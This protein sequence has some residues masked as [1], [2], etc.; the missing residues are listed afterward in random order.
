MIHTLTAEQFHVARV[1]EIVTRY[2]CT[3]AEAEDCYKMQESE[4]FKACYAAADAGTE[5]SEA[6]LD[7]LH[8]YRRYR[9]LHD[10]PNLHRGYMLPHVRKAWEER[11]PAYEAYQAAIEQC[12]VSGEAALE[13][14]RVADKERAD[15]ARL[16][17]DCHAAC[18]KCLNS[19]AAI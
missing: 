9:I 17:S 8:E 19:C 12:R 16:L 13:R 14:D 7:S 4:H 3:E 6:V 5:L 18:H 11:R 10:M 15:V 1:A 2:D